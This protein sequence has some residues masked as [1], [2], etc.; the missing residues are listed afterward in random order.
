MRR[1]SSLGQYVAFPILAM[2]TAFLVLYV[3]TW[4]Y[5]RLLLGFLFIASGLGWLMMCLWVGIKSLFGNRSSLAS[6]FLVMLAA[7]SMYGLYS[8]FAK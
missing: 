8:H 5:V 3:I 6:L 7:G 4:E 1:L 2:L